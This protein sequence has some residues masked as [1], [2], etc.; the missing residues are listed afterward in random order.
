MALRLPAPC[1]FPARSSSGWKSRR[2]AC[3]LRSSA[4]RCRLY[5]RSASSPPALRSATGR[6]SLADRGPEPW[7]SR[8]PGPRARHA[9][10]PGL[11][12][13]LRRLGI[14]P[15]NLLLA[16]I[17]PGAPSIILAGCADRRPPDVAPHRR[18]PFAIS[19]A[20]SIAAPSRTV[21]WLIPS[22]TDQAARTAAP[23]FAAATSSL[24]GGPV[25][26]GCRTGGAVWPARCGGACPRHRRTISR[27]RRGTGR[28]SAAVQA[29]SADSSDGRSA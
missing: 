9:C 4:T 11:D 24:C 28:R 2:A 7:P 14:R 23:A 5:R 3:L 25:D 12:G 17:A 20:G 29:P 21:F 26:R 16:A 22:S 13:R 19:T 27:C 1:S 10:D 6:V 18:P 8:R 15:H